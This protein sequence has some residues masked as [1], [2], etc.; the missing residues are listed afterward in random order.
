MTPILDTVPIRVPPL[1]GEAIDSWLEAYARRL[2]CKVGE[3]LALAG[4]PAPT[5]AAWASRPWTAASHSSDFAAI[6][7]LT[8]VPVTDLDAMT[9]G[10][11]NGSLVTL[12]PTARRHGP[13]R[14]WRHL[15]G[16][17]FC[18][19][20][21]GETTGRWMLTWRLPWTFACLVH[22]RLLADL[23]D[24]CGRRPRGT[25]AGQRPSGGPP[26][27]CRSPRPAED[28][29]ITLAADDAKMC[30]R[31]LSQITSRRLPAGGRVLSAARLLESSIGDATT[32]QPNT[33][34]ITL[35]D[36][37]HAIARSCLN[38]YDRSTPE[39]LPGVVL[40]ILAELGVDF[41]GPLERPPTR[42]GP[43]DHHAPTIAFAVTLACHAL[44]AHGT[45]LDPVIATWLARH[46]SR[47]STHANPAVI[48][49]RW[50]SAEPTVQ[51]AIL[52]AAAPRTRAMDRLRFRIDGPAPGAPT[53]HAH[54]HRASHVPALFW[55][56]WALRL[57]TGTHEGQ[58]LPF[59]AALSTALVLIGSDAS[60][61]QINAALGRTKVK[62]T[63][64][65]TLS[66]LLQDITTEESR[67]AFLAALCHLAAGLDTHGSPIDYARRRALFT[68]VDLDLDLLR[69]H[70]NLTGLRLPSPGMLRHY[71]LR[72]AEIL[73]GHHPQY[74][75]TPTSPAIDHRQA[76]TY[77]EATLR[78]TG[79]VSTHLEEQARL[80]LDAADI[81]EPVSWEPPFTWIPEL[82]WPGPHPDD[83]DIASMWKLLREGHRP[84]NVAQAL[85]TTAEHIWVAALRHPEAAG[86]G[87]TPQG[88]VQKIPRA[89]LP[90]AEQIRHGHEQGLSLSDLATRFACSY[91]TIKRLAAEYG[92]TF[93]TGGRRA[94]A[95]D[96]E[97]LRDQLENQQRTLKEIAEELGI[98]S[99][100]LAELARE[101][102]I[103]IR[104]RGSHNSRHPL[105]PYG[106]PHAFTPEVWSALQ[107]ERSVKRARR[108]LAA[109]QHATLRQAAA[110]LGISSAN[111]HQLLNVLERRTGTL[112]FERKGKRRTLT[113]TEAGHAF[114]RNVQ[115]ALDLLE[116][117]PPKTPRAE[118]API[119]WLRGG[120]KH[121]RHRQKGSPTSSST[122]QLL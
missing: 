13:V 69:E 9:W 79:A 25:W 58:C 12:A 98:A 5:R 48:L 81:H 28:L 24:S 47:A 60:V 95:I 103:P 62:S 88:R 112:L 63:G 41:A 97:W 31:Q 35:L 122:A 94:F 16:S 1:P 92:I 10:R 4:V 115:Q 34:P 89:L 21:L 30:G 17:R 104:G 83:L 116:R 33:D 27:R 109:T 70:F 57:N 72:V 40:D 84:S 43:R 110:N 19:D 50:A 49:K 71:R 96:P 82:R 11:F 6:S 66:W 106:G 107:G 26:D 36:N 15:S 61:E 80:I 38:A 2:R 74:R 105:T 77:E 114:S 120:P 119:Q 54:L 18:P 75:P 100:H 90:D 46:E 37:L 111:L 91:T 102:S 8:G 87:P 99:G 68:T 52:L 101:L 42:F 22:Q 59:R 121:G 65:K 64:A 56:G 86:Q 23:C 117:P 113:L 20:C 67:H 73:T 3:L 14:W 51:Q 55:P 39:E 44:T 85:A 7:A 32:G 76:R 53:E 29:P 93:P 45:G 108:F 118:D 78:N